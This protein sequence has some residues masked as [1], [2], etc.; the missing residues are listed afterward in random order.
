MSARTRLISDYPL[1]VLPRLAD[2]SY[3]LAYFDILADAGI[4]E[5]HPYVDE[6]VRLLRP[7]GVLVMDKAISASTDDDE[8]PNP[9]AQ[10]VRR[11][12]EGLREDERVQATLIPVGY[13]V[14]LAHTLTQ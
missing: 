2:A 9:H 10:A 7:G 8:Q 4:E 11:L 13:G 5:L 12:V 3:D 6:A 1:S 14:L